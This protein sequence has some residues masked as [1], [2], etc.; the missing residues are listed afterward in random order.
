M[1]ASGCVLGGRA[2]VRAGVGA[3]AGAGGGGERGQPQGLCGSGDGLLEWFNGIV[4]RGWGRA[5]GCCC[6]GGGVYGF[7]VRGVLLGLGRFQR[8]NYILDSMGRWHAV[9]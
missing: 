5:V 8:G 4:V 2:A 1:G 9:S 6:G 7:V 3:D